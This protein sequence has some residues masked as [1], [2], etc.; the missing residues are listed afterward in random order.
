MTRAKTSPM[1]RAPTIRHCDTSNSESEVSRTTGT[2]TVAETSSWRSSPNRALLMSRERSEATAVSSPIVKERDKRTGIKDQSALKIVSVTPTAG[3]G[4]GEEEEEEEEEAGSETLD[5][6][7]RR[8]VTSREGRQRSNSEEE[9]DTTRARSVA[10]KIGLRDDDRASRRWRQAVIEQ[11]Q[12]SQSKVMQS[13]VRGNKRC[14]T[15]CRQCETENEKKK[16][17]E[18]RVNVWGRMSVWGRESL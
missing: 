9:E 6:K 3:N 15:V 10:R 1:S 16:R 4:R 18:R 5:R 8:K 11:P 12:Q 14:K 7:T 13:A 2:S 17:E